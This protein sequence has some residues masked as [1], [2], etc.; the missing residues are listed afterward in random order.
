MRYPKLFTFLALSLVL[1]LLGCSKEQKAEAPKQQQVEKNLVPSAVEVKGQ[2]ILLNLSDL[3]V[4]MTVDSTSKEIV[5]TPNLKGKAK[6]TNISKDILDIRGITL[7]YVDGTGNL[8]A[9]KSG[10]KT[11]NASMF[12]KAFKP[13]ESD[14]V[15]LDVTIPENAVKENVLGKIEANVTYV[16]SPLK[17]EKLVMAE[18]VG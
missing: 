3:K 8:I 5:G 2:D 15:S 4:I 7:D 13:G 6:I 17:Q 16:P 11:T 14:E 1:A 10:E 12:I 9:F 18:K